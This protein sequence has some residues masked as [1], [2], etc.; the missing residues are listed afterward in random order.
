MPNISTF[1]D[2]DDVPLG[3]HIEARVT[4]SD[5]L[6]AVIGPDW[7]DARDEVGNRRLDDEMTFSGRQRRDLDPVRLQTFRMQQTPHDLQV[8][9]LVIGI[10]RVAVGMSDSE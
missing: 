9:E 7:L 4:N 6:V 8:S 10:D 3:T 1:M 2:V 5:A